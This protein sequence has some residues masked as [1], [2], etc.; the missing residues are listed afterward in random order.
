MRLEVELLPASVA[1]SGVR[2]HAMAA[3]ECPTLVGG[4]P[5]RIVAA[6]ALAEVRR[7]YGKCRPAR[8]VLTEQELSY[9]KHEAEDLLRHAVST[10]HVRDMLG[11]DQVLVIL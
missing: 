4:Q 1:S 5:M 2:Q 9:A 8:A 10:F 3:I 6:V 11:V 7:L